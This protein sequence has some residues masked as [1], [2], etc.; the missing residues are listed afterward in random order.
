V[1][2]FDSLC[3]FE[4]QR[5]ADGR[6]GLSGSGATPLSSRDA[7]AGRVLRVLSAPGMPAVTR[8]GRRGSVLLTA[9]A[10]EAAVLAGVA[11]ATGMRA[12]HDSLLAV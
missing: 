9:G 7:I 2:G 6:R 4:R 11:G 8:A 3:R 10:T 5:R 12:F 1:R